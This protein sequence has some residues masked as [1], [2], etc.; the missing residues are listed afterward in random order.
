MSVRINGAR[1]E[2]QLSV[3]VS[4]RLLI[5]LCV[6]GS[7]ASTAPLASHGVDVRQLPYDTAP[8]RQGGAVR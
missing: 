7:N 5:I 4:C 1:V 8:G 6:L 2:H 3:P